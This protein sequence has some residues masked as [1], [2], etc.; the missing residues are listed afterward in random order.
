MAIK[1]FSD[2]TRN[3]NIHLPPLRSSYGPGY[4]RFVTTFAFLQVYFLNSLERQGIRMVCFQVVL[5]II[6]ET[7]SESAR[8]QIK[9]VMAKLSLRTISMIGRFQRFTK[10]RSSAIDIGKV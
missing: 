8:T 10:I 2:R 5:I 7:I 4:K 3:I 9:G 1:V 6:K